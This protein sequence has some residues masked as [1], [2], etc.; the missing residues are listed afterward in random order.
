MFVKIVRIK[1]RMVPKT[2]Y[3]PVKKSISCLNVVSLVLA[4]VEKNG[5][6]DTKDTSIRPPKKGYRIRLTNL[7][8]RKYKQVINCKRFIHVFQKVQE[9]PFSGNYSLVTN[10]RRKTFPKLRACFY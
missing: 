4:K 8:L 9:R 7:I 2:A 10:R 3:S 1:L 5:T 6:V